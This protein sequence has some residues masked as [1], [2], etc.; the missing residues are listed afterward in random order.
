MLSALSSQFLEIGKLICRFVYFPFIPV[1]I[2]QSVKEFVFEC[3]LSMKLNEVAKNPSKPQF[4]HYLFETYCILIR[5]SAVENIA[6]FEEA[7]FPP[8][9]MI[10]Q[11]DVIEFLPYVFQILGMLCNYRRMFLSEIYVSRTILMFMRRNDA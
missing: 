7:I 2:R 4:N 1:W 10:L 11:Q 9:Q 8:F 5:A 6:A 3:S